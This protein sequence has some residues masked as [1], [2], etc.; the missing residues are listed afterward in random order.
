MEEQPGIL[1][2]LWRFI[3]FYRVRKALGLVRAA[4]KQFT[5]S[6]SGIR[7]AFDIE[8]NQK[9]QEYKQ[10]ESAVAEV[11]NVIETKRLELERLNNE[12]K[13][14]LKKREG[15]LALAEK[16]QAEGNN[17]AFAQHQAAFTR[18]QSRINEVE[19]RQKSLAEQIKQYEDSMKKY[20]LQL[21]KMQA[22]IQSLPA[23]KAE[24]I[25]DFVS[26]Q[27]II[28]LNH[29]LMGIKTSFEDGPVSL[30]LEENRRLTAQARVTEKMAGTNVELQDT[31]YAEAGRSSE[32]GDVFARMLAAR[33]AQKEAQAAPAEKEAAKQTAGTGNDRPKI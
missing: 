31:M 20:M 16:A 14:L 32:S 27:R 6:T 19:E 12:E 9:V 4:N 29:R 7:D 17:D 5:G 1:Q 10:L 33:K 11:E 22:Y 3:T 23:K 18:F 2:A 28:E 13:D 15:A 30:V 8:M 26:A 21:T 25:A 24:A